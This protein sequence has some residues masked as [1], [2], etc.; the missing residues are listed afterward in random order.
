MGAEISAIPSLR[1]EKEI[2]LSEKKIVLPP[3]MRWGILNF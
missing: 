2:L 3:T 1:G